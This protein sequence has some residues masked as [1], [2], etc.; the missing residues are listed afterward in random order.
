[1]QSE[2]GFARLSKKE[3][4]EKAVACFPR[5]PATLLPRYSPTHHPVPHPPHTRIVLGRSGDTHAPS[6]WWPGEE[7]RPAAGRQADRGG[8]G[9]AEIRGEHVLVGP[10]HADAAEQRDP[11]GRAG[12]R[13]LHQGAA[14]PS[15]PWVLWGAR[16]PTRARTHQADSAFRPRQE[17]LYQAGRDRV[18][19]EPCTQ[20]GAWLLSVAAGFANHSVVEQ[21][22]RAKANPDPPD[23]GQGYFPLL[24]ACCAGSLESVK[25]LLDGGARP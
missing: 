13:H 12:R 6:R 16:A 15:H 18:K 24:S 22:L 21:L 4:Q 10:V 7:R 25:L 11:Q 19:S 8:E 5:P 9:H 17:W 23:D 14:Q 3:K 2:E 20:D 1:M